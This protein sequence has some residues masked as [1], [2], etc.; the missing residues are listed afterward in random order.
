MGREGAQRARRPLRRRAATRL[1]REVGD[2][3]TPRRRC[4]RRRRSGPRAPGRSPPPAV[5]LPSSSP[6]LTSEGVQG[7]VPYHA[8]QGPSGSP[9]TAE[10][11]VRTSASATRDDARS[12]DWHTWEVAAPAH[13]ELRGSARV[14]DRALR[15]V[16]DGTRALRQRLLARELGRVLPR[17][18]WTPTARDEA[19]LS[20]DDL[21]RHAAEVRRHK[22]G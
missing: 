2:R 12:G 22:P 11:T 5:G 13:G 17:D 10:P 1:V 21:R 9:E 14:V 7:M 8:V 15:V 19:G 3:P 20:A 16:E 4:L 18:H 6:G